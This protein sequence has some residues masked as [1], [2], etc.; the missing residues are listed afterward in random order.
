M[1]KNGKSRERGNIGHTRHRAKTDKNKNKT[2][3][4]KLKDEQHRPYQKPGLNPGAREGYAVPPSYKTTTVLLIY[5]LS[6]PM[7]VL[8]VIKERKTYT[9]KGKDTLS[10]EMWPTFFCQVYLFI[11]H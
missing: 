7:E 6:S 1:I 3:H 9:Q 4:R 2:Q 8:S 11:R 5:I 10:F